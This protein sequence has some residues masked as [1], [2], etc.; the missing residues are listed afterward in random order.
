M[1]ARTG[2][3]ELLDRTGFIF[4][5]KVDGIRATCEKNGGIRLF[6]R[7]CRD[8]TARYPEFN[9]AEVINAESC[10]LDGEIVLYN[11]RGNPDFT[12]IM[13]RHLSIGRIHTLDRAIRY[14]AFDILKKDGRDLTALPL[15]ERKSILKETIGKH[16]HLELVVF[17]KDGHRLWDFIVKRNAEGV[18]AKKEASK[19]EVGRRSNSWI[20]I[21]AFNSIE[22]VIVGF[23]TEKKAVSAVAVAA[24]SDDTLQFVGKVGTGIAE[25]DVRILREL[26]EP[27]RL[28]KPPLAVPAGYREIQW[29]EPRHVAEIRYLEFGRQ[30]MLRNPVFMRLRPDK[31]P[32]EC[33]LDEQLA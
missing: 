18:I 24:Y 21:K 4:E 31:S 12:A 2:T 26:L 16:P 14:V 33:R 17:T 15:L 13:Q 5:P 25:R 28:E 32:D 30:G 22:A 11:E 7:S 8:I 6:N 1:L 29:V 3:R 19:Y 20:K 23:T 27:I 9:F 10:T